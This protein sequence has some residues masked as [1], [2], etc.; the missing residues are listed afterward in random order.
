M[1]L[2]CKKDSSCEVNKNYCCLECSNFNLCEEP[3]MSLL[4]GETNKERVLK[5]CNNAIKL[6]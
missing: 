2:G 5:L 4:N 6:K 3:C 1:V